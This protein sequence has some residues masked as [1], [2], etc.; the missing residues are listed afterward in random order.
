MV[1]VEHGGV[2]VLCVCVCVCVCVRVR[3]C[4]PVCLRASVHALTHVCHLILSLFLRSVLYLQ[5]RLTNESFLRQ[6]NLI[7]MNLTAVAKVR[8]V[9]CHFN[10][11]NF[12]LLVIKELDR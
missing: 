11:I 3:A 10:P 1:V 2:H 12:N 6:R 9:E 4:A 8:R 5:R 7:W